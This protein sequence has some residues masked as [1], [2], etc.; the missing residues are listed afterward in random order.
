VTDP[1]ALKACCA[2]AYASPWVTLVLG[3]YW[4]PG[5]ERL[6]VHLGQALALTEGDTV[7]DVAC[8]TG[9][10]ARLLHRTFGCRVLGVDLGAAQVRRARDLAAEAGLG[11]S[12][13]FAEADAESLPWPDGSLDAVICECALCTFPAPER[14]VA[15]WRRVLRP[16]GRLGITDVTRRGA[17]PEGLGDLA[18]WVACLA[19]A[20]SL[21]G[22]ASLLAGGG[23]LVERQEDRSADLQALVDRI[24]RAV[25]AWLDF[26]GPDDGGEE[27]TAARARRLLAEIGGAVRAGDL[28]Y[29]LLVARRGG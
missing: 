27:G 24:G 15:E 6:T 10:A 7:G 9:A 21:E 17:L 26:R 29:G 19:G 1:A 2:Q 14:A 11:E 12:V 13:A 8:G 25:L 23:F 3:E 28:G 5:G 22:Y 16:G 20:R 4:H 18:A